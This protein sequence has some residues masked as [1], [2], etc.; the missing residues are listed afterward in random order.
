MITTSRILASSILQT[1]IG[2]MLNKKLVRYIG[3]F[4]DFGA[5]RIYV[6]FLSD[7]AFFSSCNNF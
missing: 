5:G 4:R 3:G 7:S 2:A 6:L 1:A